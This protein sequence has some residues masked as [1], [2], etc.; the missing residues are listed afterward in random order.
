MNTNFI[1]L[2]ASW[3]N[4]DF[5]W[6][7]STNPTSK[8]ETNLIG[9]FLSKDFSD[10]T[11]FRY[12]INSKL[13]SN[14]INLAKGGD[15]N[16]EQLF[17]FKHFYLDNLSLFRYPTII[18]FG[19]NSTLKCFLD[20]KTKMIG[21]DSTTDEYLKYHYS[22]KFELA[23]LNLELRSLYH[24]FSDK[25]IKLLAFNTFMQYT[26]D[27]PML[28]K[29][30]DLLSLMSGIDSPQLEES[31]DPLPSNKLDTVISQGLMDPHT[32]HWTKQG[33]IAIA[34]LLFKEIRT[35]IT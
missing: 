7:D 20:S 31:W 15:S 6:Y 30:M 9:P 29:G 8:K 12:I 22:T 4:G 5:S 16:E 35:N 34:N 25:P 3:V 2:G 21:Y 1:T 10:P 32:F 11:T 14:H 27:I 17:K 13:K 33:N 23:K 18:L 19:I 26:F 28:F 24:F